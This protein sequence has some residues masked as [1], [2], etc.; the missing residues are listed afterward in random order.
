MKTTDNRRRTTIIR[1]SFAASLLIIA[2]IRAVHTQTPDQA[3]AI[4]LIDEAVAT[5]V[6]KVF[7]FTDIEH[8]SVFR[9]SDETHPVAEMTVRDSYQKGVGKKYTLLSESGSGIVL[10]F[11]LKP[12]IDNETAINQPGKVEGSWFTSANYVMELKPGGAQKLNGRNCYVFTIRPRRAAPN[13]VAGTLWADAKDGTLVQI[14]GVASKKP[15]V[16]AGATHMMR[17]YANIDGFAMAMHARAE[18]SSALF[19]RTVVV[20]DYSDYHLQLRGTK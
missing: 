7:S 19:G 12:L 1:A 8:Y 14:D 20:I 2:G 5:R 17:R 3:A 10:R 13:M 9:G 16:F 4:H 15:S 11:G 6:D 18:S